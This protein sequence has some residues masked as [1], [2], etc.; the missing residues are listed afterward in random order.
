MPE[1]QGLADKLNKLGVL[2][3]CTAKSSAEK[4]S[5]GLAVDLARLQHNTLHRKLTDDE[6]AKAFDEWHR[7]SLAF[8]DPDK[9]R[10]DYWFA[11]LAEIEK[12]R[13]LEGDA[14]NRKA[15][16][17]LRDIPT[18]ELPEVPGYPEAPESM[19]RI[20]G[21]CREM[22]RLNGGTFYLSWRDAAKAVPSMT[23]QKA[24]D[25]L[26]LLVRRYKAIRLVKPGTQGKNGKAAYY[27]YL[28]QHIEAPSK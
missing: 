8:L 28:P 21:L 7:L 19:R 20:L 4:R 2:H 17:A 16:E 26:H 3:A 25:I 24:G 13:V 1:G 27:E 5:F 18:S 9:A 22:H 6:I 23:N 10:E 15:L 14:L 11:L 12:V